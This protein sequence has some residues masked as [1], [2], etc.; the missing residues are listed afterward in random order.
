M[1]TKSPDT[2]DNL[3]PAQQKARALAGERRDAMRMRARRIRHGVAALAASTFIFSGAYMGIQL[4]NGK[5]PSLLA[6]SK[7]TTATTL[8]AS[9]TTPVKTTTSGASTSSAT[10][11]ST[12][13]TGTTSSVSNTEAGGREGATAAVTTSQS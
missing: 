3:T 2:P 9:S 12:A 8:L 6:S 5:D 11:A 1:P 13:S 7:A 10:T 4:A